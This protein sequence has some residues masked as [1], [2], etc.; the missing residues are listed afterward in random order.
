MP[1]P[2]A[3]GAVPGG[4]L[5]YTMTGDTIIDRCSTFRSK[6]FQ[7]TDLQPE[8]ALKRPFFVL[9]SSRHVPRPWYFSSGS[10]FLFLRSVFAKSRC[11]QIERTPEKCVVHHHCTRRPSPHRQGSSWVGILTLLHKTASSSVEVVLSSND[12]DSPRF[13]YHMRKRKLQL[14]LDCYHVVWLY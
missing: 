1:N 10:S 14:A 7:M 8:I 3:I 4:K 13:R 12:R 9:C 5:Q 2:A 6:L 11:S